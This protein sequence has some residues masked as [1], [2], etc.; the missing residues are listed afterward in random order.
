MF[1]LYKKIW[2]STTVYYIGHN[3]STNNLTM[4][5]TLQNDYK[6]LVML[7]QSDCNYSW[8]FM[9]KCNYF[10][11]LETKNRWKKHYKEPYSL[12]WRKWH[13]KI[14]SFVKRPT[15]TFTT[16]HTSLNQCKCNI[17]KHNQWQCHQCI[18]VICKILSSIYIFIFKMT[19]TVF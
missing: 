9:L 2:I 6:A 10:L 3:S 13:Q 5:V 11:F 15:R 14:Q 4:R 1:L 17:V 18:S 12:K 8:R 19:K 7:V 16:C